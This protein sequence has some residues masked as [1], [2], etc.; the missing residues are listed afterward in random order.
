MDTMKITILDDGTVKVETN[1]ISQANHM[2]AEAFMRE[3]RLERSETYLRTS[4]AHARQCEDRWHE[5]WVLFMQGHLAVLGGY[6]RV[7]LFLEL[8]LENPANMLFVIDYHYF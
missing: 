1:T 2:T 3:G 6:Y 8:K 4:L 5:G 7:T